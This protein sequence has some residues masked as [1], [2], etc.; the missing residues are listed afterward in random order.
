MTQV[1]KTSLPIGDRSN[2]L[3]AGGRAGP[4]GVDG[5]TFGA[6]LTSSLK[7]SKASMSIV[8]KSSWD[9]ILAAKAVNEQSKL[10]WCLNYGF[11]L[12][13]IGQIF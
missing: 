4:N 10:S 8:G 3:S 2:S 9:G 5:W 6:A 11:S 12:E 7:A 13:K 1:S